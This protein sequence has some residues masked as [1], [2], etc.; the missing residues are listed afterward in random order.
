MAEEAAAV[1][2]A[3][4]DW[5]ISPQVR[6]LNDDSRRV[7]PGDL[8]VAVRGRSDD[9]H[10]HLAEAA[11]RGAVAAVVDADVGD[12]PAGLSLI[13]VASTAQALGELAS[14]WYGHPSREL[15]LIGITG[16]NGKTTV[17]AMVVEILTAAGRTAES[18]GTLG[19]YDEAGGYPLTTPFP[20]QLQRTLRAMVERGVRTVVME[21][22]SHGL[23]QQRTAGCEIDAA[24]LTNL[25]RD[26]LDYHGTLRAYWAAK[27]R[28]FKGLRRTRHKERP[29][30]AVLPLSGTGVAAFARHVAVDRLRYG[31]DPQA[32]VWADGIEARGWGSR[33]ILHAAGQEL[34]AEVHMPGVFNVTNALAAVAAALAVGAPLEAAVEGLGRL[35]GVAGRAERIALAGRG[36]VVIDYAHNPGALAQ[37]LEA[38]RASA[39]GARL[40]SVFGGRGRRD[41]GKLPGMGAAAA[42]FADALVLTSDSPLDEDPADLAA[43]I[44]SGIPARAALVVEYLPERAEAI[45]RAVTLA[46]PDGVVVITGR[47]HEVEQWVGGK[48]LHR[49]D[50]DMVRAALGQTPAPRGRTPGRPRSAPTRPRARPV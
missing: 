4:G 46:G 49:R 9:G 40:V 2:L 43:A 31:L 48:V 8:F 50:A 22:S 41:R 12:A 35:H 28:L 30:V 19:P 33:F 23:V 36:F 26:H 25:G 38:A 24:V 21:V 13:R 44:R 1:R 11:S 7:Q 15:E 6:G 5:Q 42:R 16:T 45:A 32:D 3:D 39:P 29:P 27:A 37:I 20:L 10:L 47:G 18:I 17:A 14:A 34:P